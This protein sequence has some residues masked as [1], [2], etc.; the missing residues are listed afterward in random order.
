MSRLP[1]AAPEAA[2]TESVSFN[3]L[4]KVRRRYF[5]LLVSFVA[6]PVVLATVILLSLFSVELPETLDK[7]L[8]VMLV[9][10]AVIYNIYLGLCARVLGKNAFTWVF[11]NLLFSPFG[12][13]VTMYMMRTRIMDELQDIKD[14]IRII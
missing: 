4:R 5:G 9:L 1:Y 6:F 11:L 8:V 10:P 2:L 13:P 14:A 12:Y 3:F 7:I